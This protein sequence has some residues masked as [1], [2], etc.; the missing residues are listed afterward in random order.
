MTRL[1]GKPIRGTYPGRDPVAHMLE[2][3]KGEKLREAEQLTYDLKRNVDV[4]Y[5]RRAFA[6]HGGAGAGASGR[7][8][9]TTTTR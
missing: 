7:S 3:R 1:C 2:G 6:F 9:S 4:D 5:Q 8:S